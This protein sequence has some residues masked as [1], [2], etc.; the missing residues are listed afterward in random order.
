MAGRS[1]LLAEA[2]IPAQISGEP[3][4]FD[5]VFAREK[6]RDYR[7]TLNG[8]AAL[9]SRFN[10]LLRER[11]ILKGESKYYI[12]LAHTPDDIAFTIEAWRDAIGV[13]KAD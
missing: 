7:G 13:L 11:G 9:L 10:V 2:G 12:S 5:V 6:V 4:L 3:P 1:R 8:D